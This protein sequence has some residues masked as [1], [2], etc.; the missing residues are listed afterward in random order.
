MIVKYG[1]EPLDGEPSIKYHLEIITVATEC[2]KNID[3][4]KFGI[5]RLDSSQAKGSI[6]RLDWFHLYKSLEN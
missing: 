2:D 3:R 4:L 6:K 5:T 1:L